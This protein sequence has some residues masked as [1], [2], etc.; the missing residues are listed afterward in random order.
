MGDI[1]AGNADW[2]ALNEPASET[3]NQFLDISHP[4]AVAPAEIG[5]TEIEQIIDVALLHHECAVHISLSDR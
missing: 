5:Q 1:C 3:S 2:V 4:I